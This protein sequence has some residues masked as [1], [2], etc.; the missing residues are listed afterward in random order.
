MSIES[1]NSSRPGI[2][3]RLGTKIKKAFHVPTLREKNQRDI[4]EIEEW[5]EE[6]PPRNV[7]YVGYRELIHASYRK[8][9][10]TLK[11]NPTLTINKLK[12]FYEEEE[13]TKELKRK[14]KQDEDYEEARREEAR[15]LEHE[16]NMR[17]MHS[18]YKGVPKRRIRSQHALKSK[19]KKQVSKK[20][21]IKKPRS[22]YAKKKRV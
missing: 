21:V 3:S 4:N 9:L 6:H 1:R 7:D 17:N 16:E 14:R 13:R 19:T 10:R 5:L 22:Q 15:W 8:N 12:D 11:R 2:F 20:R 18:Y